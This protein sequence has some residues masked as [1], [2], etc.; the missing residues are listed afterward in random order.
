[1]NLDFIQN[2]Q[3]S[4]NYYKSAQLYIIDAQWREN[5]YQIE[6]YVEDCHL[7]GHLQYVHFSASSERRDIG[8]RQER[9]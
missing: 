4:C 8:C 2:E 3:H 1:M 6:H 9:S 5:A 7:E